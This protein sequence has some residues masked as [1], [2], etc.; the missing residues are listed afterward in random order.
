VRTECRGR[1]L[2]TVFTV[3]CLSVGRNQALYKNGGTD[4]DAVRDVDSSETEEWRK[5]GAESDIYD[6]GP[7][8]YYITH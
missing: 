8:T 6:W 2:A 3:V 1:P 4:P 7:F 5:V